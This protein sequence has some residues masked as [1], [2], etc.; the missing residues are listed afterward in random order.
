VKC[1]FVLSIKKAGEDAG[2]KWS[3]TP[4]RGKHTRELKRWLLNAAVKRTST[5]FREMS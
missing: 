2:N 4:I 5:V 3:R 1:F